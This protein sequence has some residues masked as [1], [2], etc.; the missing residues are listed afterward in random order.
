MNGASKSTWRA[1]GIVAFV[2]ALG[3][4]LSLKNGFVLDD[5]DLLVSNP[6]VRTAAG[7]G[8]LLTSGLF[9][10]TARPILA[11]YYRPL[12]GA[13]YWLSFQVLGVGAA[14]Q[15]GLNVVLHAV[16]SVL[17][18]RALQTLG[19]RTEVA[20]IVSALF[21]VHPATSEI[22][23]YVGGRQ[24]MLAAVIA[25]LSITSLAKR[26]SLASA[27]L[28]AFF[29]VACA[30][31]A[32]ESFV[33]I[34]AIV[35]IVAARTATRRRGAV[36]AAASVVAVGAAVALRSFAG[37]GTHMRATGSPILWERSFASVAARL[38]H[39]VF[40]PTDLA[41][42]LTVTPAPAWLAISVPLVA[43]VACVLLVH[44]AAPHVR[45]LALAGAAAMGL[46]VAVHTPIALVS[47]EISDRYAY[48]MLVA[49]A[50]A[51]GAAA[52]SVAVRA[53]RA[54]TKSPLR[55]LIPLFAG[56]LVLA[57]SPATLARDSEWSSEA[58]LQASMFSARPS[59]PAAQ[60]AEGTRR[61]AA[62]DFAAAY[63][64]C[65]PYSQ[66]HPTSHRADYCVGACLLMRGE[67]RAAADRLKSYLEE[68]PGN[69][70]ARRF[71][72]GALFTAGDLAGIDATLAAWGPGLDASPEVVAAR[73]ELERRRRAP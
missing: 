5:D 69:A 23:A 39:D 42:E 35:P 46:F 44:F 26:S 11:D 62:G 8:K 37:V 43:G 15:H 28:A 57:I 12:S 32:H 6:F 65:L 38:L 1:C 71:Y 72:L 60:F 45:T 31:L 17:L 55:P 67:P 30:A 19:A 9:D 2:A 20:A 41:F 4:A 7:L 66:A 47:G 16:V 27:G 58:L 53:E 18:L 51:L 50:F 24:A 36:A 63:P 48:P 13:L 40:L 73:A 3:H 68:R 54:A 64:L 21:A 25:L 56:L 29:G 49:V 22:V 59:D 10:A 61:L 14:A 34:A 33:V 70:A 52:E